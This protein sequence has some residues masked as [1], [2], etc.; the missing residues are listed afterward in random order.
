MRIAVL[1]VFIAATILGAGDAPAQAPAP[2]AAPAPADH[3]EFTIAPYILM[4]NMQGSTGIGSLPP[5]SVDA[6]PSD[7][8]SHLQSGAMLYFQVKKGKWAFATDA[9][10]MD[11]QQDLTPDGGRASGSV[12]MH[13][14]AWE[15]FLLYQFVPK[16]EMGVGGFGSN[17]VSELQ[18]AAE[19]R[20]RADGEE[21]E[22]RRGAHRC[23]RCDGRR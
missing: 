14:A 18:C 11:L 13:Q 20:R 15:G 10:F 1:A 9:L 19:R 4:P 21:Q 6:N 12:K 8:F 7:I 3:W 22:R 23:S 5:V 17:V 2:T 16:L